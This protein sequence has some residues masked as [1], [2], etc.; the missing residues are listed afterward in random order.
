LRIPFNVRRF[1]GELIYF[2]R[3]YRVVVKLVVRE[4]HPFHV[5][6]EP[7]ERKP[8]RLFGV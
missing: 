3:R 7:D 8:F 5:V 1:L 4:I 6:K 2:L